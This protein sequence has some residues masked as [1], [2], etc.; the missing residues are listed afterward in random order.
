MNNKRLFY[1]CSLVLATSGLTLS[2][3]SAEATELR[4]AVG[5]PAGVPLDA[6]KQYSSAVSELTDDQYSVRI[7]ELSLLN[8]SEMSSGIG[9][10]MADIGYLLTA[11]SPSDYPFS[12]LAADMSM[13]LALD[14]RAEGKEGYDYSGAML[15]YILLNCPECLDEFKANNQVYTGVVSTPTYGMFCNDPVT[16]TSD[17]E[18]KRIRISGAPWARWVRNFGASPIS[19]PI[20]ESYEA[21][22]QG[23]I[24]CT[25]FSAPELTNFNLIEVV[26][27]IN[28]DLPGGL[29]AAG[30][31]TTL[32][33]DRWNSFDADTKH[34]ML[35]AGS[36]MSAYVTYLYQE[37]ANQ[38]LSAAEER[39]INI[40]SADNALI[41][42]SKEFI[43]SDLEVVPSYYSN[44]YGI[45]L[46]RAE[47]LAGVMSDL[48]DKWQ[49]IVSDIDD[50]DQLAE[51]YWDEIYS[52]IDHTDYA[53]Q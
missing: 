26:K 43:R 27:N 18:G 50:P 33:K 38:D 41:E 39:G 32:N 7:F 15:E 22:S 3:L 29:F 36:V 17:I 40:I 46:E 47:E 49:V 16:T 21:L 14:D 31:A 48:I 12:N 35:K 28:M 9:D 6:A 11:Y 42:D 1:T 10:G 19:L 45:D 24:D 37:Q 13:K 53:A 44:E 30:G 34:A 20:G 25:F 51:I 5:F 52:K 23:V 4:Y 8:H 2:P